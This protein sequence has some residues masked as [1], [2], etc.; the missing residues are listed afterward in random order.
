MW[1]SF[2]LTNE[3]LRQLQNVLYRH[4]R[5]KLTTSYFAAWIRLLSP[6]LQAVREQQLKTVPSSQVTHEDCLTL[7]HLKRRFS[8][9][10]AL[11][12]S[13]RVFTAIV[14]R[15][16]WANRLANLLSRQEIPGMLRF[17]LGI[18]RVSAWISRKESTIG[19]RLKHRRLCAVFNEWH[20]VT[21]TP[22]HHAAT[23][24]NSLY[25]LYD[26]RLKDLQSTWIDVFARELRQDICASLN[27]LEFYVDVELED[28]DGVIVTVTLYSIRQRG[29]SSLDLF[30]SLRAKL[31]DPWS[32]LRQRPS[33]SE[34]I[35]V[36]TDVSLAQFLNART[37]S[38]SQRR[39][40]Y[41]VKLVRIWH[42]WREL[43]DSKMTIQNQ[44]TRIEQGLARAQTKVK[45]IRIFCSWRDHTNCEIGVRKVEHKLSRQGR[46]RLIHSLL[47]KWRGVNR[48]LQKEM[49][50]YVVHQQRRLITILRDWKSLRISQQKAVQFYCFHQQLRLRAIVCDWKIWLV[51]EL[52]MYQMFLVRDKLRL[53][54]I[55]DHWKVLRYASPLPC[56]CATVIKLCFASP[57]D[58]G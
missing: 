57:T 2:V 30:E 17:W 15:S 52:K 44:V 34:L 6:T 14:R 5:R 42:N 16:I 40:H 9:K 3:H 56:F 55:I 45:M 7:S 18:W 58:F 33:T 32:D 47:K 31:L 46:R 13:F 41:K 36:K 51:R 11:K 23:M 38:N 12:I 49:Q 53:L 20:C 29:L 43:K 1:R 25:L 54:S 21:S 39:A 37:C 50:F 24:S 8:D 19:S 28:V 48:T 26:I 10:V 4:G 35:S 22:Q 27:L